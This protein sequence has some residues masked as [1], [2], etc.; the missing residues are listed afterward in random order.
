MW[1]RLTLKFLYSQRLPWSSDPCLLHLQ[2][3]K[4]KVMCIPFKWCDNPTRG[5]LYVRKAICQL[6]QFTISVNYYISESWLAP[7]ATNS[8]D[9]GI[10]FPLVISLAYKNSRKMCAP[11]VKLE[12]RWDT[13]WS[14]DIILTNK[15]ACIPLMLIYSLII[16]HR[17]LCCLV[18][19]TL[20]TFSF[21]EFCY[22]LYL[23]VFE[24]HLPTEKPKIPKCAYSI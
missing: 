11:A 17:S 5:V 6:S 4:D 9:S 19:K 10:M 23:S 12:L 21:W 16:S 24:L 15:C 8:T 3:A 13:A 20:M 7:N 22:N 1:F 18:L 14:S 2:N